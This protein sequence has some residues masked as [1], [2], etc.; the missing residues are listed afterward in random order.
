PVIT[1]LSPLDETALIKILSEPKNSIVKQYQKFFEME[2]VSLEFEDEALKKIA[3]LA[4]DRKIG[5]RGLRS[6]IENI[7]T[8]LMFE[9]PSDKTIKKVTINAD[10]IQDSTK[11]KIEH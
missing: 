8:D 11:V 10:S 4:L 1:T 2:N 3:A 7:M 6:I 5:A 9:I